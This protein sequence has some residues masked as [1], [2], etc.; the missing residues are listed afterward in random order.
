MKGL[1]ANN[2]IILPFPFSRGEKEWRSHS[3]RSEESIV[4]ALLEIF[5]DSSLRSE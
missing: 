4:I 2:M 5:L 3:E 1:V